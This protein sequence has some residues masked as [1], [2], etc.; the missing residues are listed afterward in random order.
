VN[1]R[2]RKGEGKICLK[3]ISL[4]KNKKNGDSYMICRRPEGCGGGG[5]RVNKERGKEITKPILG[6]GP[7]L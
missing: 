1:V 6:K 7:K 5:K 2:G 4:N 3:R